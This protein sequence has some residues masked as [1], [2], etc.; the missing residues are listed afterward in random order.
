VPHKYKEDPSLGI[1]VRTQRALFKAGTL[2]QER[3]RTIDEIGFD[4]N[5]KGLEDIWNLQFKK[6]RDYYEKHGH[7]ELFWP[8]DRFV[9]LLNTLTNTPRVTLPELQAMCR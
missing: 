2:D 4:F 9:F 7:C 8:V 5:P 3:K 6:L 1:W